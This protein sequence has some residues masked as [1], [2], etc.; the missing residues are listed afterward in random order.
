MEDTSNRAEHS[1]DR[2]SGNSVEGNRQHQSDYFNTEER[3]NSKEEK[4]F[5]EKRRKE[6]QKELEAENQTVP[7]NSE[8]N[9]QGRH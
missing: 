4:E 1:P 6:W 5:I 9:Q 8:K 2:Q 3:R 7:T